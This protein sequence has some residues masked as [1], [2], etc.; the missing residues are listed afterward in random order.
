MTRRLASAGLLSG[1]LATLMPAAL[2]S[3]GTSCA[4]L[5]RL[6]SPGM[7]V[8]TAEQREAGPLVLPDARPG[9]KPLHLPAACRVTGTLS[10][11]ADS[12][13]RFEVWMPP[14]GRWN[15]RLQVVGNTGFLGAVEYGDMAGGL[16]QGYAVAGSDAGHVGGDLRFADGHPERIIDWSYRAIHVTTNA[17]KLIV[18]NYAGRHPDYSYFT[19]CNTG[20]H[21]ALSEAQR[22]PDD[23]DGIVAGAPANDRINEIAGYLHVWKVTHPNGV[24]ILPAAK[25]RVLGQ[26]VTKACDRDDGVSD[27]VIEHPPSC[28]FD[29]TTLLCAGGDGPAC[30]TAEQVAAAKEIYRGARNPRTGEQIFPG[31]PHGSESAG[32]TANEG[33]GWRQIIDLPEPRRSEFW[34][35]F[36]FNN[37]AFDWWTFDFDRDLEYANEKVGYVSAVDPALHAFKRGGGKLLLY[38]GWAD[39]ILPGGDPVHYYENVTHAMGG[40]EATASFA[41]LFMMPGVG[42]CAGGPGPDTIEPLDALVKWVEDGVAPDRLIASSLE[43]GRVVRERPLCPYP[44]IAHWTGS[45]STDK[46]ESFTCSLTTP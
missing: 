44:Q 20:G 29:L 18:R 41:R 45:G 28:R 23:F 10:P 46:A 4:D 11:S 15:G 26:A 2:Q 1:F 35:Y 8:A 22:Y 42:H 24:N 21:Q 7:T 3:E 25:L 16:T 13:I 40:Y 34:N 39:P 36:V 17:A 43:R 6:A 38:A 14:A 9:A 32:A 37:P 5:L 31:W 30:L 33:P 19:G 27:G 12:A